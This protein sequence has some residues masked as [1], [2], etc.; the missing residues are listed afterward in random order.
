MI[1]I[2]L[3]ALLVCSTG[4][5][6]VSQLDLFASGRARWQLPD[7]VIQTLALQP[8]DRVADLGSGEGYFLPYLSRAV[9][10]TGRVYAVDVES[11]IVEELGGFDPR[12]KTGEDA[13]FWRWWLRLQART[14]YTPHLC[15]A[16][17]RRTNSMRQRD[18]GGHYRANRD[19]FAALD[20]PLPDD[21]PAG[22]L[23][24]TDATYRTAT[25]HQSAHLAWQLPLQ[26]GS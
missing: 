22:V 12:W 23:T 1:R 17:R 13:E 7:E 4:C 8:G 11:E 18:P 9:G 15:V 19:A 21:A 2:P 10:P 16:Y 24:A 20:L 6:G 5:S 3:L 25:A 26:I 14:V